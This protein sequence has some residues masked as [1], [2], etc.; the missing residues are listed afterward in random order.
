MKPT[1]DMSV[2]AARIFN[3]DSIPDLG[4]AAGIAPRPGRARLARCTAVFFLCLA[5]L[6]PLAAA[7][8]PAANLA[9]YPAANGATADSYA[10]YIVR[11]GLA[12]S[13]GT[14]SLD[15]A[16]IA[17]LAGRSESF[18]VDVINPEQVPGEKRVLGTGEA[19]GIYEVPLEAVANL[20]WDYPVLKTI[21]PRLQEAKVEARAEGSIVVYEEIGINFL[22]IRIGYKIRLEAYRDNLPDGAVGLRYRMTESLDGKL[23]SADS[24][25][26]LKEVDADGR[27][28]LYMRTFSTSGMR[29]PGFG[30]A[31]AMK[32][33]TSGELSGQVD[34]VAKEARKR[35]GLK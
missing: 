34:S 5:G 27:K 35:A 14:G 23:Y 21:S 29:N 8:D 25:W 4:R 10:G 33:F 15:A 7:T 12:G 30:V 18:A 11:Y 28:M 3:P 2:A 31:A 17:K 1:P 32:A 9:A 20:L 6:A 24:S 26:Y 13:G 16:G 19:H 22:G